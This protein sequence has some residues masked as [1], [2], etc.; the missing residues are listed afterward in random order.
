MSVQND[1]PVEIRVN[2]GVEQA[3]IGP[4]EMGEFSAYVGAGHFRVTT[5]SD[6]RTYDTPFANLPGAYYKPGFR[7]TISLTVRHDLELVIS[8]YK[9]TEGSFITLESR[10]CDG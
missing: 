1:L 4:G 5:E 9:D 2:Y 8:P 6:C 7:H 3:V 10:P